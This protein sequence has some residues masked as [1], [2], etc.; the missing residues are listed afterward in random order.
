MESDG[1]RN[2]DQTKGWARFFSG[3]AFFFGSIKDGAMAIR[4]L[5]LDRAGDVDVW[6][7]SRALAR[8]RSWRVRH[9]LALLV[10]LLILAYGVHYLSIE[11]A[12]SPTDQQ[13]QLDDGRVLAFVVTETQPHQPPVVL[14]HGTHTTAQTWA[15]LMK[16]MGQSNRTIYAVDRLGYGHSDSHLESGLAE[17][18]SAIHQLIEK[19]RIKP[20]LVG[21][22]YG[23]PI[24]LKV[25]A[26]HP[27]A[28]AGVVL[29]AGACD[30]S[31][32]VSP[33]YRRF[34]AFC[35]PL[36]PTPWDHG[37]AEIFWLGRENLAM[38]SQ[39]SRITVPVVIIHGT[40]DSRCPF[41]PTVAYLSQAFPGARVVRV[42]GGQH[43]LHATH[44]SL[45]LDEID[46][47]GESD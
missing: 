39:L 37:N 35:S 6:E 17:H 31:M 1:D 12:G 26:T 42:E 23:A 18:A 46:R 11:W 4:P 10:A 22:S 7:N 32:D 16:A 8:F 9:L 27:A 14:I 45:L 43:N 5:V 36:V 47:V 13:I 19:M 2:I 28:V 40:V 15:P 41:Q 3:L 34:V 30:P 29:V 20:I 33:A 25:A 44:P 24:A 38:S 21:H